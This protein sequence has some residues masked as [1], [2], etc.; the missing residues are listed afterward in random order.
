LRIIPEHHQLYESLAYP[1]LFPD[2]GPKWCIETRSVPPR[3]HLVVAR[4][5]SCQRMSVALD[6]KLH[7]TRSKALSQYILDM[8]ARQEAMR[9]SYIR[10]SQTRLRADVYSGLVDS[11]RR[12]DLE[13][14][15]RMVVLPASFTGSDRWYH[16]M[17]RNAMMWHFQGLATPTKPLRS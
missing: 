8:Y 16:K 10:N 9:L 13:N 11:I 17:Y 12:N 7:P 15:G 6:N 3:M 1:I 4:R 14:S 2:G 5:C